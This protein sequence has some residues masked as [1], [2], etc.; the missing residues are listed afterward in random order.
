M[1]HTKEPWSQAYRKGEDRMYRQ[2]VFDSTGRVIA[3]LAWH[4]V[5]VDDRATT[6]D[7]A[8]NAR[9]IVA[10]VNRLAA[11]RTEDIENPSWES[12]MWGMLLDIT[13]RHDALKQQRDELLAQMCRTRNLFNAGEFT[14]ALNCIADAIAKVKP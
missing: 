1:E 14:A 4:P 13:R 8:A 12:G 3:T 7:R 6:T 2:E 10:C 9:R 5:K 11:F